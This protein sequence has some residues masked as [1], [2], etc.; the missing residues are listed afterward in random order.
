MS[1]RAA[2]MIGVLTLVDAQDGLDSTAIPARAMRRD[3]LQAAVMRVPID[4][5]VQPLIPLNKDD[6]HRRYEVLWELRESKAFSAAIAGM[7]AA[8]RDRKLSSLVDR[9]VFADLVTW[10]QAHPEVG[11]N[12]H[13]SFSIKLSKQAV[14]DASFLPFVRTCLQKTRLPR[15]MIGFEIPAATPRKHVPA[16]VSL[17]VELEQSGCFLVLDNFSLRTESFNALR[18]PALRLVKLSHELTT[19]MNDQRVVRA[20]IPAITQMARVLGVR[21]VAKRTKLAADLLRLTDFGIDYVQSVAIA[22]EMPIG[23]LARSE[24]G[25]RV[26]GS[27][28][29]PM[30]A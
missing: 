16:I 18:L 15:G 4:L 27:A 23:A 11:K 25:V 6:R 21:T 14:Y 19:A 20:A 7:P 2:S 24:A 12:K 13:H 3:P 22:P 9:R 26:A 17:A 8:E 29:Q 1:L 30:K 10:L 28:A 5:H